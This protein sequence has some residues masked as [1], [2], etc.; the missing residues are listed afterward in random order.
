MGLRSTT[1]PL[2]PLRSPWDRFTGR[3]RESGCPAS[4][5]HPGPEQ[6]PSVTAACSPRH[7]PHPSPPHPTPPHHGSLETPWAQGAPLL[8]ADLG[9]H[10][11]KQP[12]GSGVIPCDL[13]SCSVCDGA[14]SEVCGPLAPCPHPAED[15]PLWIAIL[16]TVLKAS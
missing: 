8:L 11:L 15:R 16:G 6:H 2:L 9:L 7:L 4:P 14:W 12:R 13:G 5:A 10:S 1:A 3:Q